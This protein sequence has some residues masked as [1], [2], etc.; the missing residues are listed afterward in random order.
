MA[1]PSLVK[2]VKHTMFTTSESVRRPLHESYEVGPEIGRGSYGSVLS[3]TNRETGVVCA[4][5]VIQKDKTN[6]RFNRFVDNELDILKFVRH[7][8]IVALYEIME[9]PDN[10]Y[11]VTELCSGGELENR[12][13]PEEDVRV[14]I[15]RLVDVVQY[16]HAHNLVHR[17][18][19]P[20][21]IL[22]VKSTDPFDI[23]LGDFGLSCYKGT[24]DMLLDSCGTPL[25]MAPEVSKNH[26][27]SD[28]CDIWSIGVIMYQLFTGVDALLLNSMLQ[29]D[30]LDYELLSHTSKEAQ[31]LLRRMLATN[32]ANRDSA[33]EILHNPWITGKPSNGEVR[34]NVLEL[35]E[36]M[37]TENSQ[38]ESVVKHPTPQLLSPKQAPFISKSHHN[39]RPPSQNIP[40]RKTS[41]QVLP[42]RMRTNSST[43]KHD[44]RRFTNPDLPSR[45]ITSL[46][47]TRQQSGLPS[48][49]QDTKS[50]RI[51]KETADTR[52]TLKR[53]SVAH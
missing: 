34:M 26:A 22:L 5:K 43:D 48:Y 15:S 52:G 30:W 49:M 7:K 36:Q 28:K 40:M 18:I 27:Y 24:E 11:L 31:N 50:S 17:D 35:M 25:Y 37:N 51:A 53:K 9:T 2:N 20:E 46:S 6:K 39:A 47:P 41:Q 10:F 38:P 19:K 33:S 1:T 8:N 3:A 44:P 42:V 12:V 13:Y 45:P 21:N 29:S 14:I 23:R 16:L 32:P 4:V